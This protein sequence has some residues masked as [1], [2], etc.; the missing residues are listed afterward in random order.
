MSYFVKS[1][2]IP[3]IFADASVPG[4]LIWTVNALTDSITDITTLLP[5]QC[6]VTYSVPLQSSFVQ[7]YSSNSHAYYVRELS[8]TPLVEY[9]LAGSV[10]QPEFTCT[11]KG[12]VA[13]LT[14]TVEGRT[15]VNENGI[16]VTLQKND[17]YE[18][19]FQANSNGC[20]QD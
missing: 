8:A 12:D 16:S 20:A 18:K 3:T 4:T 6:I 14:W 19:N 11:A 17:P 7:T 9:E 13:S 1:F 5:L 2:T 15:D 10:N